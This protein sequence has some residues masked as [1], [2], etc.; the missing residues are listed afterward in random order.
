MPGKGAG[1]GTK[2]A[3]VKRGLGKRKVRVES[4]SEDGVKGKVGRSCGAVNW[5]EEDFTALLDVVEALLV[6]GRKAWG[7]IYSCFEACA[8]AHGRP[9]CSESTLENR[10]KAVH[11]FL[12]FHINLLI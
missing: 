4:E 6:A 5:S 3:R 8:K 10:Y 9:V 11:L 12:N 2:V 7:A 1:Y